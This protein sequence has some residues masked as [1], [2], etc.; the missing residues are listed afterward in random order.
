LGFPSR[1]NQVTTYS[2]PPKKLI[3]R[4]RQYVGVRPTRSG[5]HT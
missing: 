4:E 2:K 3:D 1:F 5:A